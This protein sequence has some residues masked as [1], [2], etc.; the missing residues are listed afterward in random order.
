MKTLIIL[1]LSLPALC[2][3]QVLSLSDPNWAA[4]KPHGETFLWITNGGALAGGID[5]GRYDTNSWIAM[6][7]TNTTYTSLSKVGVLMLKNGSPTG[8]ISFFIYSGAGTDPDALVATGGTKISSEI[9]KSL[10]WY[11]FDLAH[12][13]EASTPY[14]MVAKINSTNFTSFI[15]LVSGDASGPAARASADGVT[16]NKAS[17]GTRAGIFGVYVK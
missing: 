9:A 14:W 1:L 7:W 5:L 11:E 12:T 4:A 10:T 15:S 13:L 6:K 16:W 2:F 8:T 3:G 17:S